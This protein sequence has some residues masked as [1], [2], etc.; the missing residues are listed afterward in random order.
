MRKL[1]KCIHTGNDTDA[2]ETMPPLGV[3]P[4]GHSLA[5]EAT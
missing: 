3:F 1:N 2:P 5:T 4:E